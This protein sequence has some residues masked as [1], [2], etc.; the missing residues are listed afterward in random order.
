M[1]LI[2]FVRHHQRAVASGRIHC[3]PVKQEYSGLRHG[4]L[5][6][7]GGAFTQQPMATETPERASGATKLTSSAHALEPASPFTSH[8]LDMPVT[9]NLGGGAGNTP[10]DF[11]RSLP[12][13]IK[14]YGAA[15]VATTISAG[16]GVLPY[17]LILLLWPRI[18]R[19]LE[20]RSDRNW[21]WC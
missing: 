16:L 17:P 10:A 6:M 1:L 5:L 21:S 8:L 9:A 3:D 4:H 20:V 19:R 13:V 18:L 7:H 14:L 12:P 15:C 2:K 11:W